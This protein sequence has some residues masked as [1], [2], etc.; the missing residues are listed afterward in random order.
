MIVPLSPAGRTGVQMRLTWRRL[1][2]LYTVRALASGQVARQLRLADVQWH[3]TVPIFAQHAPGPA[4]LAAKLEHLSRNRYDTLGTAQYAAWLSGERVLDR[5]SVMLTFDDG[6]RRFR[7]VT[8]PELR[9]YGFRSVLFI[10]PGLVDLASRRESKLDAFVASHMLTWDEIAELHETGLVDIQS[11]GMWHN[12]VPLSRA[13][14]GQA[15]K[16]GRDLYEILDLLPPDGRI[17]AL[18]D[19]AAA[20]TAVPRYPSHPFYQCRGGDHAADLRRSKA[21][22]E[23]HL[24][25]HRVTAFAFPWWNGV[26]SAARIARSEGYELV[27]R[28]MRGMWGSQRRTTIDP[29]CIGRMSFDWIAC[30][31]GAGA[32]S[33]M[34]LV[35]ELRR[36]EHSDDVA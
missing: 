5:S 1:E 11:H 29:L 2:R 32:K 3:E 21:M 19:G 9:R 35:G 12:A 22:I 15:A 7:D 31:P 14:S 6:M 20:E 25:G 10:C 34:T 18:F 36:G 28:G 27:F 17:E 33:F 16:P 4:Y 13:P 26:D 8:F 23:R 30:L 24:P